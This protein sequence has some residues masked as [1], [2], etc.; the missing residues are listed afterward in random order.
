MLPLAFIRWIPLSA[1]L[2]VKLTEKAISSPSG[3]QLG[4]MFCVGW[5]VVVSGAW[6][7]PS[8]SMIQMSLL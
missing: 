4:A 2:G 1:A 8:A 3:D 6:L 5:S 7:E